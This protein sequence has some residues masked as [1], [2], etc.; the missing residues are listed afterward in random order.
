MILTRRQ[1]LVQGSGLAALAFWTSNVPAQEIIEISMQGREDGSHVWFDPVGILIEPGQ[2]VRWTN[3][4]PGNAHTSTSYGPENF[5]RP[6]RCPQSA[7]PWNSDYLLPDESYAVTFSTK[8]VYD[9]YC[10]PHEHAG[11]V[12]RII[13]GTADPDGWMNSADPDV[14]LPDI[15]LKAFPSVEEIMTR[16]IVRR[17]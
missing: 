11:M 17:T 12:G 14:D 1:M 5:G 10:I 16:K 7:K 3:R 4:N 2:T 15:A 9:Y 6:L 13:V 8:G